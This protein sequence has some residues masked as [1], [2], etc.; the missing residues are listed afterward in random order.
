MTNK[1]KELLE[2]LANTY[3]EI[4]EQCEIDDDFHNIMIENNHLFPM[5]IEDMASEFERITNN[6][7]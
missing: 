5:S 7:F 6:S 2:Q 3:N 4:A 1:Q